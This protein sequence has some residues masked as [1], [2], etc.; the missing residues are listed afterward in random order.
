MASAAIMARLMMLEALIACAIRAGGQTT[1][2]LMTA[3]TIMIRPKQ[4][5]SSRCHVPYSG[6][7]QA[8]HGRPVTPALHPTS[9]NCDSGDCKYNLTD[10]TGEAAAVSDHRGVGV[11][12]WV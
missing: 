12:T 8:A 9:L 3:L 5:V 4:A 2:G 6:T 11:A 1:S 10:P 7:A